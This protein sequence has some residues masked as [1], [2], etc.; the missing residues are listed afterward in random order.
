MKLEPIFNISRLRPP[1][2]PLAGPSQPGLHAALCECYIYTHR[3]V[4]ERRVHS[5]LYRRASYPTECRG[6]R[7]TSNALSGS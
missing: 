7:G 3:T 6:A 1:P 5:S 4:G 2:H